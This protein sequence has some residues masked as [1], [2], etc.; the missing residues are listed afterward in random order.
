MISPSD[1]KKECPLDLID[2]RCCAVENYND[3][4]RVQ[5]ETR[6]EFASLVADE[7]EKLIRVAEGQD[8]NVPYAQQAILLKSNLDDFIAVLRP[9]REEKN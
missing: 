7:L 3:L 6:S 8:N 4:I 2:K 5:N 1:V 9:A